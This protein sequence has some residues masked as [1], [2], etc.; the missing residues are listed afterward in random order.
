[1][2]GPKVLRV[3]GLASTQNLNKADPLDPENRR[4]SISLVLNTQIGGRDDARRFDDDD[5]VRT[6]PRVA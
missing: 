1:M 3:L 6:M 4:I 5:A 2:D